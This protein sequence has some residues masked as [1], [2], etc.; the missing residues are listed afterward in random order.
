MVHI[1]AVSLVV[2]LSAASQPQT[3]PNFTGKWTGGLPMGNLAGVV[4]PETMTI[5]QDA[6]VLKIERRYGLSNVT[7][8]IKLDGTPSKNVVDPGAASRGTDSTS[9]TLVSTALWE[10]AK[11][12]ITT[13]VLITNARSGQKR[14][15]VTI[16]ALSLDGETLVVE[17]SDEA[18]GPPPGQAPLRGGMIKATKVIYR[19]AVT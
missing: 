6:S 19:R 16:E 10:S 14:E 15:V 12:T 2:A 13:R 8:M 1:I 3:R 4:G 17:R 7:M 9:R 18:M 5:T 11:L